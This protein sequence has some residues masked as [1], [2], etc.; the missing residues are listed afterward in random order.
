MMIEIVLQGYGRQL[1]MK[2][3]RKINAF[4][5]SRNKQGSEEDDNY[6]YM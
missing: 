2:S 5:F 4:E 1:I 3:V 6:S